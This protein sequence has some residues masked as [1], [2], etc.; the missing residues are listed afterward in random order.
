MD[1]E[2]NKDYLNEE[3]GEFIVNKKIDEEVKEELNTKEEKGEF[4]VNKKPTE[5]ENSNIRED[6][7]TKQDENI[8]TSYNYEQNNN[9]NNQ[10]SYNFEEEMQKIKD[11]NKKKNKK[12]IG[13]SI[14]GVLIIALIACFA[15]FGNSGP[16]AEDYAYNGVEVND[17]FEISPEDFAITLDYTNQNLYNGEFKGVSIPL[18][19]SLTFNDNEG[20]YEKILDEKNE[21]KLIVYP[22]DD[23]KNIEKII[24]SYKWINAESEEEYDEVTKV[25]SAYVN[26]IQTV[27][28][29]DNNCTE[30][31]NNN[32]WDKL[33]SME[34]KTTEDGMPYGEGSYEDN[35]FIY[36]IEDTKDGIEILTMIPNN[37]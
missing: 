10:K 18:T 28:W 35:K 34:Y 1:N 11:K 30:E 14:A 22:N 19:E 6:N 17:Y 16:S 20:Y 25:Y 7:N 29:G 4:I 33:N 31:I 26:M 8:N 24:L 15:L 9:F 2:N 32:M 37:K 36:K 23:Y 27:I 21:L 13:F 12:I 3:K 5:E